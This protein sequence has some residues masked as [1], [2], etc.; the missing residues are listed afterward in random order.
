MAEVELSIVLVNYKTP[1]LLR[2][3]LASV[4]KH[5]TAV[6]EVIVVDN[7]SE[8][9]S[10]QLIKGEF[11]TVRWINK[12]YNSGFARGN[13]EGIKAASGKYVLLL[14][15]D[16][17][18]EED[19]ITA[20]LTKYKALEQQHKL[21]LL[22]CKICSFSGQILPSVHERFMGLK[23]L[24]RANA[25]F[26]YLFRNKARQQSYS[27]KWY[28][29]SHFAAH[30]SGAFMLFNKSRLNSPQYWLDE[31]FFLYAEDVEW[32][33]RLQ[34]M[35]LEHYYY[36]EARILHKDSGS[37]VDSN[38]KQMQVLLSQLLFIFKYYGGLYFAL[39]VWLL[40]FNI[41]LDDRLY[42]G[43]RTAHTEAEVT[44]AKRRKE[45]SAM[46][47]R[48]LTRLK[49]NYKATVNSATDFLKYETE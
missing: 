45:I 23:D 7:N 2:Q 18:L 13:N 33:G 34:K 41:R 6:F 14:N 44:G 1:E 10:E 42:N 25:I 11:P 8:D 38:W 19:A 5:T 48:Y 29:T 39:Y 20:S 28:S 40:K 22:G 15:S 35:G 31:D 32:C 36:A 30:I 49:Q 27:E 47:E 17:L 12:N 16:A 26:I 37:S 21:G 46:L 43:K 3:C 4:Y 24:L 9:N